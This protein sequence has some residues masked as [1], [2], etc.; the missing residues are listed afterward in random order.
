MERNIFMLFLAIA[1]LS[2]SLLPYSLAWFAS[3]EDHTYHLFNGHA[4]FGYFDPSS[5]NGK[6]ADSPFIISEPKHFYNFAWLQN[7]G[8]FKEKTYLKIKD[9]V[10]VLDMA[11]FLSG[12]NS[13]SGAIPPIGTSA[14]PF[15]VNLTATVPSSKTCGFRLTKTIGTKSPAP[16]VTVC[17]PWAPISVCSATLLTAQTSTTFSWKTLR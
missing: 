3:N 12:E 7:I 11:G 4:V 1:L 9:N 15:R 10:E 14:T 6:S 13:V 5:G 8:A 2:F 17:K 16:L